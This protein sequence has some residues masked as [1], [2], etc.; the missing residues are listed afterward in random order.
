MYRSGIIHD[1]AHFPI[2]ITDLERLSQLLKSAEG[3]LQSEPND[4]DDQ[5][6]LPE[7]KRALSLLLRRKTAKKS[8]R[9]FFPVEWWLMFVMI[10]QCLTFG[11]QNPSQMT[12]RICKRVFGGRLMKNPN[13]PA[14]IAFHMGK[15]HDARDLFTISCQF[16][17]HPSLTYAYLCAIPLDGHEL[18]SDP[19]M[20]FCILME[21]YLCP[22]L[23]RQKKM[24]RNDW[25]FFQ[26][27]C[28]CWLKTTKRLRN[29]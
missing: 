26:E 21:S 28:K 29:V 9:P 11:L 23:R 2:R 1:C 5:P 4:V 15:L 18:P 17:H 22:L 27:F 10:S 20:A 19:D 6:D 7:S 8:H 12:L 24:S 13:F 25:R 16:S 14:E 3:L